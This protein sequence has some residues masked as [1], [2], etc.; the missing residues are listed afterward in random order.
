MIK[1][2]V[3]CALLC[4]SLL[5]VAC[6]SGDE[7]ANDKKPQVR[8]TMI[9]TVQA[10]I[11]NVE[12]TENSIGQVES[13]TAPLIGAE[14][15]GRVIKVNFDAGQTVTSGQV[16]AELDNTDFRL[17]RDAAKAE[18]KRIQAL[19]KSQERQVNR[20]QD[21]VKEKFM[22]QS[23]LD[24]AQGQLDALREQYKGAQAK[25]ESAERNLTKARV[26]SPI[27]GQIEKRMITQG[28]YVR[29]GDPLF[30][31]TTKEKLHIHLPLP[32]TLAPHI[33]IGLPVRLS[34][35]T[36]PD[37]TVRGQIAEIRPMVGTVNR[38][39]DVIVEVDNPGDWKPGASV[40]AWVVIDVHPQAVTVPEQSVVMRPAGEVIYV[41]NDGVAEQRIVATGNRQEGWVEILSGLKGGETIAL[42][43]AGYLTDKA[44]VSVQEPNK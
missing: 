22:T 3:F 38:A 19:I 27:T 12:V 44:P 30:Q 4:V 36:D 9:T 29:V 16:M 39:M 33:K 25:L 20:Y 24:E 35:P 11:R 17:A 10:V 41:I 40:N 32:E 26:L 37:K 28:D 7:K 13:Q 31:I 14:I 42:D 23:L 5:L 1:I 43:G 6:G 8:R 34:T 21:M 2:R 15:A 18:V